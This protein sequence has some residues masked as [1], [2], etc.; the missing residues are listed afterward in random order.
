M[1]NRYIY[2][3]ITIGVFDGVHLGHQ[4]VINKV[5]K[6]AKK[7]KGTPILITFNPHPQKVLYKEKI[8]LITLLEEKINLIKKLGIKEVIVINFNKKFAK[9]K[10]EDFVKNILYKRLNVK[11]I[12]IGEDYS[13]GYKKEGDVNYL[14]K[15]GKI[16]NFK[17][18]VVKKVSKNGIELSSSTIREL[19]KE[20]KI[21][22]ANSL[23]E[24]FFSF[25]GKVIYGEKISYKTGFRTANLVI[26]KEKILPESGVYACAVDYN[27]KK[28]YCV[29]N[30]GFCP[31]LKGK[32]KS[33][34][35]HILDFK[36]KI[37]E[38]KLKIY[39]IDKIRDEIAF[40]NSEQL[41][42]Q[43]EKDVEKV[44][45]IISSLHSWK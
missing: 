17:V 21:R 7:K 25:E 41:K 37:Y 22:Q 13:F 35:V 19:I 43:I 32:K 16:Y 42:R 9:V 28:Y 18:N 26:N 20:G 44:K 38:K 5:V 23:L 4:L 14:K 40:K 2:P 6:R 15:L 11:E 29:M 27:D 36:N 1:K 10:A 34:E 45:K 39:L 3:V 8:F 24:R 31:T 30:I 33:Y 12:F